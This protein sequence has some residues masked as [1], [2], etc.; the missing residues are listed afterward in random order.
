[1]SIKKEEAMS[2]TTDLR[3]GF[4]NS[5]NEKMVAEVHMIR[6]SA[7]G[8]EVKEFTSFLSQDDYRAV[9]GGIKESDHYS[10]GTIFPGVLV[11]GDVVGHSYQTMM[12]T[13]GDDWNSEWGMHFID[14]RGVRVA[15]LLV[16]GG[17]PVRC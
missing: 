4:V 13:L 11:G 3:Q 2:T 15:T 6:R 17:D 10:R 16:R 12:F 1:M 14:S 8:G 5:M 7:D 9:Y